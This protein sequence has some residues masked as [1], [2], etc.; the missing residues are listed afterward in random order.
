MKY[1]FAAL[2]A[3]GL[4]GGA[5]MAEDR[6]SKGGQTPNTLVAPLGH[7]NHKKN[8]E[9]GKRPEATAGESDT[10]A[11][12]GNPNCYFGDNPEK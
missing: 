5:S 11:E 3:V 12:C 8:D 1:V 4:I 6:A 10:G 9:V 2:V 7:D